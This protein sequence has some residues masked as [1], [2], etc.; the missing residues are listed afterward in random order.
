MASAADE[1]VRYNGAKKVKDL[2]GLQKSRNGV[3]TVGSSKST[4]SSLS[5]S[6]SSTTTGQKRRLETDDDLAEDNDEFGSLV[7]PEDINVLLN[8]LKVLEDARVFDH[9]Y[10]NH[11]ECKLASL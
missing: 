2:L 9:F 1:F 5:S 7:D 4:S 3:A 10:N 6:S 11:R 8:R